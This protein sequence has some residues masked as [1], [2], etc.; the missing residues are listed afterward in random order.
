MSRAPS[1]APRAMW[2][3]VPT[4]PESAPT[5]IAES[6]SASRP[7]VSS[8]SPRGPFS[9]PSSRAPLVSPPPAPGLREPDELRD[10]DRRVEQPEQSGKEAQ[11]RRRRAQRRH[12]RVTDRPHL[13][14]AVVQEERE[15]ALPVGDE[16]F[17]VRIDAE[18]RG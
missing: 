2:N 8:A 11:R 1:A 6:A 9:T 10:D 7:R 14:E 5:A 4:R 3:A 12:V 18:R 17:Q 15:P 16:G 13:R